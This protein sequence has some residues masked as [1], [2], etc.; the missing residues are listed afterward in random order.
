MRHRPLSRTALA[1]PLVLCLS[2]ASAATQDSSLENGDFEQS[3]WAPDAR[4]P[5]WTHLYTQASQPGQVRVVPAEASLDPSSVYSGERAAR[6]EVQSAPGN[7]YVEF[8]KKWYSSAGQF[9]VG[10]RLEGS[11]WV[12][13]SRAS[14]ATGSRLCARELSTSPSGTLAL[15]SAPLAATSAWQR[16]E[17]GLDVTHAST[18]TAPHVLRFQLELSGVQDGDYALLDFGVFGAS[19]PV[20]NAGALVDQEVRSSALSLWLDGSTGSPLHLRRIDTGV[21]GG[22]GPNLLHHDAQRHS[23]LLVLRSFEPSVT[24][25]SS[26]DTPTE[27]LALPNGVQFERMGTPGGAHWRVR[28]TA[29]PSAPELRFECGIDAMPS[30]ESLEMLSCPRWELASRIGDDAYDDRWFLSKGDGVLIHP[31]RLLHQHGDLAR[32]RL[33]AA[34][35]AAFGLAL[36]GAQ[37]RVLD[38]AIPEE[39]P[40]RFQVFVEV[41][42]IARW[43]LEAGTERARKESQGCCAQQCKG[44]HDRTSPFGQQSPDRHRRLSKSDPDPFGS[45]SFLVRDQ[46]PAKVGVLRRRQVVIFQDA[47]AHG[48]GHKALAVGRRQR[49]GGIGL[50]VGTYEHSF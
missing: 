16:L 10:S 28:I 44:E 26:Q 30:G 45:R 42:S 5:G 32:R 15:D 23:E 22:L 13:L 47:Q 49:P 17:V 8:G 50:T 9:P 35:E 12:R 4:P 11:V 43:R 48:D 20:F 37:Q 25:F 27:I 46:P 38:F 18:P 39:A 3:S 31:H 2:A 41:A 7:G 36:H 24:R 14:L 19:D 33:A 1:L 34:C 29:S 40:R 21:D 6:L